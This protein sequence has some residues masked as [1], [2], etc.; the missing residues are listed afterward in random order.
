MTHYQRAVLTLAILGGFAVTGSAARGSSIGFHEYLRHAHT[1]AVVLPPIYQPAPHHVPTL[2][3]A[4]LLRLWETDQFSP[5]WRNSKIELQLYEAVA[6]HRNLN[7]TRFD[8]NHPLLGHLL[9]DPNFFAYAL[10]LYNSHPGRFVHYHHHLIPV[11]RG[12]AMMMQMQPVPVVTSPETIEA[13]PV[14]APIET[15][16][17]PPQSTVPGPPGIVLIA[18]GMGCV[19]A[20]ARFRRR[21]PR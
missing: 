3:N 21:N 15:G 8:S 10:H 17:P 16:S 1:D 18:I 11:I 12:C 4:A 14:P 19:A 6:Q 5:I 2:S 7:P 9:R 13:P 20:R